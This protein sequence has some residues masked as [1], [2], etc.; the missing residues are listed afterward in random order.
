VA[1]GLFGGE[2]DRSFEKWEAGE[3]L[4]AVAL[5]A[6]SPERRARHHTM[7]EFCRAWRRAR[8]RGT[9]THTR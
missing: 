4:Y 1:F 7:A 2:R 9:A 8:E 6:V 3:E 5:K